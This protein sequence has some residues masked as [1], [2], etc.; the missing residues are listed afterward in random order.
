ML[1]PK[2]IKR[3]L[4]GS[5]PDRLLSA[6]ERDPAS[7]SGFRSLP[8]SAAISRVAQEIQRIQTSHGA[9]AF[10][11]LSG[12]SLVT[13]KT[14]LMGKFAR[15]CLRTAN[16]DYN[17]RLCMVSAGAANKKT[18]G[19]DRSANP[20]SDIPEAE[21][22]FIAGSN[23]AE[24]SPITTNYVWQAREKGAKV[25]VFDPRIKP[26]ERTC[27]W[28]AQDKE[29]NVWYMG[30][31][32]LEKKHG[33]FVRASDSWESGVNGAQPG[34]IMPGSPQPGDVYRQE[35]YPPGGA[36]DQAHVLRAD[37]RVKV[38]YGSFD[39]VLATEEWSPVEPQIEQKSY[40][41]DVGEIEEHVTA[42]GHEQ[43]ELVSVTHA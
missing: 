11:V 5:H 29:G 18:F 34:I 43:F 31:D 4:Q 30:E 10:A 28:Y 6:L 25:I 32:S 39:N 15:M 35:Y 24:C 42:G 16:I 37:A 38:A 14:Y 21:V 2:G 23:V 3:Y 27:D 17:G 7:T 13:E 20:W 33:R 41:V 1:C 40:V 36:L 22:V 26:I 9:D 19:V 8:Y 12:A